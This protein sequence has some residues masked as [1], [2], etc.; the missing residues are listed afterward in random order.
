MT[1]KN[2]TLR[3]SISIITV[4]YNAGDLFSLTAESVIAQ[5]YSN[6]EYV[7]VDGGSEDGT[8]DLIKD[9][10]IHIDQWVS[11]PD[12]GLYDAMNKGLKMAKGD[13]VLFLNA[14]D[15]LHK[16]NTL[17]KVFNHYES[18]CDVLY[19]EVMLVDENR[20]PLGTRSELSTQKLPA[21]LTWSSLRSGMV[22]SHQ[23]F[24]PRKTLAPNYIEDNL[25]ADIDWVIHCLKKSR[26]NIHSQTIISDYLM[27]GLSKKRHQQSMKDRYQVLKKHYGA[28]S[29]FWTHVGII[30]RAI[31]FKIKRRGKDSY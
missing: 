9:Y 29:N 15:I 4:T 13:F 21:Q 16:S 17:T 25:C 10:A 1:S 31:I 27:G 5:D 8:V 23:A 18:T 12:K 28:W 26:K 7:V 14:G 2:T 22:V 3:P 20:K 19:G 30:F 11:E 6:I 24:I